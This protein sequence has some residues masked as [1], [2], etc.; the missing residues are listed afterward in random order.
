[1]LN[2]RQN[3]GAHPTKFASEA[4]FISD[5]SA[6][7]TLG[8]VEARPFLVTKKFFF[9]FETAFIVSDVYIAWILLRPIF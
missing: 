3:W 9:I 5:P 4:S 1:V 6:N 7:G 2:S 8:T